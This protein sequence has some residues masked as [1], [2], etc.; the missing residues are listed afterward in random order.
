[1]I[2]YA[3]FIR[4]GS[5]AAVKEAGKMNVEGKDYNVQDGDLMYIRFNV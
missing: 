1:V 4:Y 2:K 5:E 3:D